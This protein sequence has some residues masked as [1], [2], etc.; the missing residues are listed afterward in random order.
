MK[1][2][3]LLSII[4]LSSKLYAAPGDTTWVYANNVK[5]DYYNNF[6]T[7]VAFPDG[8]T[9]YRKILMIFTLGEYNCP[10]GSQYCHQWDYTVTNY[11][12]TKT[13]TVELSRFIT[14]FANSGWPRFPSTWK[15]PYVYDVTDF[16]PLLKDSATVR[17]LYRDR[18]RAYTRD[19][20]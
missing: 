7:A 11:L 15:Q 9:T 13:D 6:D 8:S 19:G 17:I 20:G 10:A 16:Y 5:L 4:I 14:P 1:K 18:A 3:F 2:L 12:L